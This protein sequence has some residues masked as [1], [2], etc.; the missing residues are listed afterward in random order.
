MNGGGHG[1]SVRWRGRA[2]ANAYAWANEAASAG[3]ARSARPCMQGAEAAARARRDFCHG[4][5]VIRHAHT[6]SGHIGTLKHQPEALGCA[7]RGGPSAIRW[8]RTLYHATLTTLPY[9]RHYPTSQLTIDATPTWA[10]LE[11]Q[12]NHVSRL[13]KAA[14]VY[15][16][17]QLHTSRRTHTAKYTTVR[18][19][20]LAVEAN[21][22]DTPTGGHGRH[23]QGRDKA[24]PWP[25]Q[26]RGRGRWA[27]FLRR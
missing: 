26:G 1:R 25:R 17:Q 12:H 11:Q 13:D 20:C 7:R 10:R 6:P 24:S 16:Y 21:G 9:A 5:L 27:A 18:C 22:C 4:H 8:Q 23:G 14:Q 15:W 3:L 2:A 19:T